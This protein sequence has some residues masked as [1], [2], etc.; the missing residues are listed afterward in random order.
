MENGDGLCN[1]YEFEIDAM[2][3]VVEWLLME[4][5]FSLISVACMSIVDARSEMWWL[6]GVS[7]L[8]NEHGWKV[9]GHGYMM[10]KFWVDIKVNLGDL[11]HK[12]CDM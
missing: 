6:C 12:Y 7:D 3:T 5:K 11:V 10:I 8:D 2:H 4:R 9:I 1:G